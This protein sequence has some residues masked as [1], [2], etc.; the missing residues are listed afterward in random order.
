VVEYFVRLSRHCYATRLACAER[1]LLT[2]MVGVLKL[3][4]MLGTLPFLTEVLNYL[5]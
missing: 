4:C 5:I 1:G 3:R 2:E